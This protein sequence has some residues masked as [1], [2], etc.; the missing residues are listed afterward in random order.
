MYFM[1]HI[2]HKKMVMIQPLL[3]PPPSLKLVKFGQIDH[4][5]SFSSDKARE[6]WERNNRGELGI[7]YFSFLKLNEIFFHFP[8]GTETV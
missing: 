7:H 4:R 3:P 8:T 2:L 5:W 6:Y 1:S